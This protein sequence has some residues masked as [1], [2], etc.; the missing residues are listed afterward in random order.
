MN[1]TDTN[2][3]AAD[4]R[5]TLCVPDRKKEDEEN[6]GGAGHMA[7][8]RG[9]QRETTPHAPSLHMRHDT[10]LAELTHPLRQALSG[11]VPAPHAAATAS[12]AV[13]RSPESPS[14]LL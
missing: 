14:N 12:K 5:P 4:A 11:W 1:S 6:R 7:P 2:T 8:A 10:L 3:T 9:F 13:F